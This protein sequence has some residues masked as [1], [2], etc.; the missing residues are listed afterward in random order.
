MRGLLTDCSAQRLQAARRDPAAG[1]LLDRLR[2]TQTELARLVLA[3]CEPKQ[4]EA[5]RQ[6]LRE[7]NDRKESLEVELAKQSPEFRH[8]QQARKATPGMLIERISPRT[9]VIEIVRSHAWD[10]P[11][12]GKPRTGRLHYD[13]FVLRPARNPP[14]YRVS[15]VELGEAGPIDR[16]VAAWRKAIVGESR[17]AAPRRLSAYSASASGNRSS[18]TWPAARPCTSSLTAI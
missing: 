12:K 2:D 10:R 16:A 18:A 5:R 14:G 13:A 11:E 6:R 7:L 4:Q 15:W 8:A 9:A 17:A 3:Q 1:P